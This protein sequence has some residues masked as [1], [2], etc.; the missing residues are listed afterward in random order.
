M[1]T[2]KHRISVNLDK[3][4]FDWICENKNRYS[5]STYINILL[6]EYFTLKGIDLSEYEDK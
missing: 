6:E 4:M 3:P 1:K 5:I 2:E